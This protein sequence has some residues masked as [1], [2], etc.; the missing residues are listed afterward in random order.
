MDLL[1]Q[2]DWK[3]DKDEANYH[4]AGNNEAS[5]ELIYR[6]TKLNAIVDAKHNDSN[7]YQ[8]V[9]SILP[10]CVMLLQF[11][12]GLAILNEAH[13]ASNICDVENE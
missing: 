9:N 10:V 6:F 5:I 2:S 4:V 1:K 11:V 13:L 12:G 3:K 8:S 7:R